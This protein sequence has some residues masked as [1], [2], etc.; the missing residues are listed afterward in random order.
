MPW[1]NLKS[2]IQ[3]PPLYEQI[4]KDVGIR[5]VNKS[6]MDKKTDKIYGLE[7]NNNDKG[8]SAKNVTNR[9]KNINYKQHWIVHT[10]P[11]VSN[12]MFLT[13]INDFFKAIFDSFNDT[14]EKEL[15][16]CLKKSNCFLIYDI[17]TGCTKKIKACV[18][19]NVEEYG[20]YINYI[21]VDTTFRNHGLGSFLLVL[22]QLHLKLE[23]KATNLHLSSNKTS[24]A[25]DFYKKRKFI[26][27]K[28][29]VPTIFQ[30]RHMIMI[31]L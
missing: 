1:Q 23:G 11:M 30:F 13:E 8:L 29:K 3:S 15:L 16:D 7:C 27:L 28:K 25:F 31:N 2:Y 12:K 22:V 10:A 19:Y 6:I 9:R 20:S 14:E 21:G 5:L 4:D 18:I 26:E 24:E 17:I